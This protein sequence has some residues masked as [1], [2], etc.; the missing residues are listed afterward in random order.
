[1]PGA[2]D[3]AEMTPKSWE[4][5]ISISQKMGPLLDA[6]SGKLLVLCLMQKHRDMKGQ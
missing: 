3:I 2:A 4:T 5:I 1:M 6:A